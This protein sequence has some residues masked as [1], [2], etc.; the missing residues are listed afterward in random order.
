MRQSNH[1]DQA[2]FGGGGERGL[3]G[4]GPKKGGGRTLETNKGVLTAKRKKALLLSLG[5]R[6]FLFT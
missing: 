3:P 1:L 6:Q 5:G 2:C 4:G